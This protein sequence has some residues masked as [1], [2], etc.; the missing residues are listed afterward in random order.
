MALYTRVIRYLRPY[1]PS[2]LFAVAAAAAYAV[3]DASAY[4]LLIPFVETLFVSGG[5]VQQAS[6]T[7]MARLLDW[8]VYRW[9]DPS[10]DPLAAIGIVI[11][12]LMTV[13]LLKNM[14]A[15]ARAYLLARAEQ[16][17][18]RDLRQEVYD[19]LLALDL[20]FFGRVRTGQI[21]SRLTTEV[22]QVRL[23]VT[24]ELS[25][26][27]SASLEFTVALGAMLLISWKLTVAALVVVPSAMA[28]WGPFVKILRRGDR[29]VL[30]LGG[31]VN[32]HVLETVA[33]MRLVKAELAED[34]ERQRFRELTGAHLHEFLRT[35]LARG[36]AAPMTEMLAA[37]GTA[38]LLWYGARLVVGGEISG[39]QFVGFLGLSLKMYQPVKSLAKF[40]ATAQPGLVAAERIFEFLDAPVEVDDRPDAAPL[41]RFVTEISF[42]GVSFAYEDD[43]PVLRDVSF[44]VPK[45]RVLAIVGPSGAGKSTAV[46]LLSRFFDVSSGAIRI[47]GRDIRDVRLR[48]LRRQMGIVSQEAV[49]FHDTVRANIAYGRPDAGLAEIEAA[50]RAANADDFISRMPQGYDTVVGERGVELSGGQ[51]QRIAIARV[52]LRDPPILVFDEA[53]SALDT[54]SERLIQEAVETLLEGR[55]VL[56]VAHRLSTIQRAH[57]IIVLDEGR[58]VEKGDHATLLAKGGR[59]ARLHAAQVDSCAAP[60]V[61]GATAPSWRQWLEYWAYRITRAKWSVLPER[62]ALYF[63]CLVGRFV[64]SVLRIRRREVDGHLS[65]AFPEQSVAWRRRVARRSYEHLG[66][67]AALFF[68]MGGWSSEEVLARVS[69]SG[70]EEVRACAQQET[71][72][73]LLTGHLGNWEM[74]GAGIAAM[75]FELDVVGKGM[76]NRRFEEDLIEMRERLGMRVISFDDAPKGVLRA[77]GRG[78]VVAL[79]GD[80][81]AHRHGI[82][83]P[84]FG[85]PAATA[86]GPAL[87]AVRT[88]APVFVGFALRTSGEVHHYVLEAKRLDYEVTADLDQDVRSL[89]LAYNRALEEAIRRAPDQYFWQHR[90]WK[91]RPPEE[92]APLR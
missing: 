54:E 24:R 55:T 91:T 22:E 26:L 79:L 60:P 53:T 5:A 87:F 23:F 51:R 82:F 17:V 84:F 90:R 6:G 2:V 30:H 20:A 37:A 56:V 36:L 72:V 10:G 33:A 80:Q 85:Q 47:D 7:S 13:L 81:N 27:V 19:H 44:V 57:E 74:A 88:G 8:T 50:A 46:D 69:F 12:M 11:A 68:R 4:I 32:A 9:A 3:L 89:M 31:E 75:G 66:R 16:G 25:R 41:E 77:L 62:L 43:H 40:P 70:F 18:S 38:I 58:V 28:L 92:Q 42:E 67:E 45:G 21:V 1:T 64:G 14:F 29:R 71:G 59:Y 86:R 34:R 35:E 39:A 61:S 63:G 83:L 48:D 15:F 65:L 76:A 73:V 49:L 52:L 78:R